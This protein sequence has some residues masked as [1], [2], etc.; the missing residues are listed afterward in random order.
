MSDTGKWTIGYLDEKYEKKI[1]EKY[2]SNTQLEKKWK[3]FKRD[4]TQNPY[5]HPKP[6]RIVKLKDSSYGKGIYRYKNEPIRVVYYPEKSSKIIY[7]LAV[8]TATDVSYKRR[9]SR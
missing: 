6:K 8:A 1:E 7:P 2:K 5:Y 4:V 9:S 3:D